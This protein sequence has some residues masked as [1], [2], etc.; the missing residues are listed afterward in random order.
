MSLPVA[1]FVCV[2]PLIYHFIVGMF[3][4]SFLNTNLTFTGEIHKAVDMWIKIRKETLVWFGELFTI[5]KSRILKS[6]LAYGIALVGGAFALSTGGK[7][8]ALGVAALTL[9]TVVGT[10]N[11]D[12]YGKQPDILNKT[13]Q[14]INKDMEATHQL[15]AQVIGHKVKIYSPLVDKLKII[16]MDGI[17]DLAKDPLKAV[18]K[19]Y[20]LR[21]LL[22]Q[23]L[24]EVM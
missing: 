10:F 20:K 19:L 14:C 12:T 17:D 18:D 6:S 22:V 8:K 21:L 9:G 1:F 24:E 23:E 16:K 11:I 4:N 3:E 15:K 7:A 2:M 5:I 13:Q